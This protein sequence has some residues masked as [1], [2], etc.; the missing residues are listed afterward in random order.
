MK[1]IQKEICLESV[2]SRL[3]SVWPA[4][5]GNGNVIFFDRD[6]VKKRQG[7]KTSNYGM[8]PLDVLTEKSKTRL[9]FELVAKIYAFYKVYNNLLTNNGQC[10][11]DYANAVEYYDTEVRVNASNLRFGASRATYE[12]LDEQFSTYMEKIDYSEIESRIVPSFVIPTEWSDGWES[13]KLYYPDVWRWMSWLLQRY[14]LYSAVTDCSDAIDCCDCENYAKK[15]GKDMYDAMKSWVDNLDIISSVSDDLI[16]SLTTSIGIFSNAENVGTYSF[17]TSDF[18]TNEDYRTASVSYNT[19]N[20]NSGTVVTYEGKPM[21]LSSGSGSKFDSKFMEKSFD[22]NG[23]NDYSVKHFEDNAAL[24]GSTPSEYWYAYKDDGTF[25]TGTSSSAVQSLLNTYHPLTTVQEVF[26]DGELYPIFESEYGIYSGNPYLDGN[27]YIVERDE[28]TNTPYVSV[29]GTIAYATL[30]DDGTYKFDFFD[31]TYPLLPSSGDNGSFITIDGKNINV[32]DG[33]TFEYNGYSGYVITHVGQIGSDAYYYNSKSKILSQN[34]SS[35]LVSVSSSVCYVEEDFL[36]EV[37]HGDAT[38]KQGDIIV[39]TCPSVLNLLE[40]NDLLIDD[41]GNMIHGLY[42]VSS[43]KTQQPPSGTVLELSYQVGNTNNVKQF[44]QTVTDDSQ[45]E[46]LQ[47]N[48]FIGDIIDSMVFY[49]DCEDKAERDKTR[50]T[51]TTS[52]LDAIKASIKKKS[53]TII[54][55]SD[56]IS[57]DITYYK[58]ATLRRDKGSDKLY[59]DTTKYDGIKCTET[60]RFPLKAVTYGLEKRNGD[61]TPMGEND[62]SNSSVGYPIYVYELEQDITMIESDTYGTLYPTPLSN[63]EMKTCVWNGSSWTTDKYDDFEKGNGVNAFP[64]FMEEYSLHM[65]APQSV[66]GDI[67]I[68]RGVNAALDKHLRLG[69]VTSLEALT[70]YG[71]GFYLIQN[72]EE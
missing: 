55:L 22:T 42:N 15:G 16:P 39:G 28:I 58:G 63:F 38:P 31:K 10:K 26:Y 67:Y 65:S 72:D 44:S 14:A 5:D 51:A 20:S 6:S 59:R 11:R 43:F 25:V 2:I 56:D 13:E 71:N 49:F 37:Y 61:V 33:A 29:N 41:I 30:G 69:E 35:M 52:S 40:S 32:G 36:V 60:V 46:T 45:S 18:T 70:Q 12:E 34:V 19:Y 7:Q 64:V 17:L 1:N 48:Y 24:E 9:P 53:D 8:V 68:N 21:I 62:H 66:S 57:C 4:L 50:V 54:Y 27:C 3:P 23:W 47:S